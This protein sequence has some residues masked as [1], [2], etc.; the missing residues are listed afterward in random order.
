MTLL[1]GSF[2]T[3]LEAGVPLY[4][5]LHHLGENFSDAQASML[6]QALV[7]DIGSGKPLSRAAARHPKS[8]TGM[9]IGLLRV[10][11]SA[12]C[13][14]EVLKRLVG[15]E[16]KA[17]ANQLKIRSALTYPAILLGVCLVGIALAPPLL[18]EPHFA[19]IRDQKVE[20]PWPTACLMSFSGW[21]RTPIPYLALLGLAWGSFQFLLPYLGQ[22]EIQ[23][24]LTRRALLIPKL[25]DLVRGI[26]TTG[27]ARALALQLEAGVPIQQALHLAGQVTGNPLLEEVSE[28]LV[29]S[30]LNGLSLSQSLRSSQFFSPMFISVVAVGEETGDVSKLVDWLADLGE[31]QVDHALETVAAMIEPLVM[32]GIGT[33]VGAMV[34][35]T[36]LPLSKA[37]D[38]I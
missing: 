12:G 33:L 17:Q 10:G 18:L 24:S 34:L 13:L 15:F 38:A 36:L 20:I 21:M 32:A 1:L 25:R 35:A 30:M 4:R 27:F 19:L 8:F 6:C 14:D 37:L 29:R 16:E 3:M 5:A 26:L 11:E 7:Q 2:A 31:T 9:Q 28:H 23:L 22:R